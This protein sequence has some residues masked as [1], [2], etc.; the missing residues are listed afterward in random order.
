MCHEKIDYE[1]RPLTAREKEHWMEQGQVFWNVS[2]Q[3]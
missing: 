3:W 1:F 2:D